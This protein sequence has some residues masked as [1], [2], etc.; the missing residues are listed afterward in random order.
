MSAV[1]G[2]SLHQRVSTTGGGEA[3]A[4]QRETSE[5]DSKPTSVRTSAPSDSSSV[6]K[7]N[8]TSVN[9]ETDKSPVQINDL[10][11]PMSEESIPGAPRMQLFF[12]LGAVQYLPTWILADTRSVQNLISKAI[13][14]K[15][16]YQ[17]PIRD[18][19]SVDSSLAMVNVS[20]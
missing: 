20:T 14:K 7:K 9:Y 15:L 18:P 13:Y 16:P 10:T 3:V 1:L 11:I 8:G 4:Q 5:S 17:P 12:V 19:E 2:E 6:F